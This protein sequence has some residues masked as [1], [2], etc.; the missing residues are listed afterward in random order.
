LVIIGDESEINVLIDK[1]NFKT[2]QE[3]DEKTEIEKDHYFTKLVITIPAYNE[4]ETIGNVIANIPRDICDD[5][6]VLVI[7]DGSTDDTMQVS[8]AAGADKI[9][10]HKKNEGLGRAFS[11]AIDNALLMGADIIVNIDADGQFNPNDIPRLINPILNDEADMVTCTRFADKSPDMPKLKKFGNKRFTNLINRLTKE[12]F[13]DTQCGFRAYSRE[14]A[15]RLTLFGRYTY[16]QE[17]FLDLIRKDMIIKEIP[18]NVKGERKGKSKLIK[19]VPYYGFKALLIILR[20][21]RDVRPLWFFGS[22]GLVLFTPGILIASTL[23][24][25]LIL[26]ARIFP[27]M[28]LVY[29]ALVLIFGGALLGVVGFIAE[30]YLRQRELQEEILYRLKKEKLRKDGE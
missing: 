23:A 28:S 19:N 8:K 17:V 26:I 25:R 12:K 29:V 6:K 22:L 16:T 14:A 2:T 5:V 21:Y 30:M 4:E 13:T 15:L 24:I 10:S 18:C 20:T 27:Y 7:N 3:T 9:F 11:S 1:N